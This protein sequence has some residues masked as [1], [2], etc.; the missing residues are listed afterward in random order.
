[1]NAQ[2]TQ[3]IFVW[4]GRVRIVHILNL[5][6]PLCHCLSQCVRVSCVFTFVF[7]CVCVCIRLFA[8]DVEYVNIFAYKHSSDNV[9]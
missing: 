1:M 8:G 3:D 9:H 7:V 4:L 5:V 6:V 2:Q